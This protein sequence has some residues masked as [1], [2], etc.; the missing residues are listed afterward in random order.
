[1]AQSAQESKL[2]HIRELSVTYFPVTGNPVRALNSICLEVRP[3]E[4]LG[5]L[6]ESGCGKST[7]AA[8]VLRLLP[9]RGKY[10]H[11]QIFF[12]DC[13]LLKLSESELDRIRGR[14]IALVAQIQ[15]CR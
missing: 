9:P 12:R 6:G 3:Q 4:I 7:L 10:E 8:A 13:D 11:G 15:P 14:Q 1:M 5:I 2:L